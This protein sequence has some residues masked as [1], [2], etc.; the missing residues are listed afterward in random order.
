MDEHEGRYFIIWDSE[1]LETV[2]PKRSNMNNSS[3]SNFLTSKEQNQIENRW[4]KLISLLP[5]FAVWLRNRLNSNKEY[6]ISH[7]LFEEWLKNSSYKIF[8]FLPGNVW[9]NG[10]VVSVVSGVM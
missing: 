5:V 3:P 4:M 7:V 1:F 9:Y 10:I 8:C 6:I 2:L